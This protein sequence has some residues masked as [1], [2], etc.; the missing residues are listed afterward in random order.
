MHV[1]ETAIVPPA[2][3][4]VSSAIHE[5]VAADGTLIVTG[6]AEVTQVMADNELKKTSKWRLQGPTVC[7]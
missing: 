5:M 6:A 2:P 1:M 4:I 3:R 7:C